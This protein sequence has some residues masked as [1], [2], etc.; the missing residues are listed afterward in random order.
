[1]YAV[2]LWIKCA[3]IEVCEVIV[4]LGVITQ[5]IVDILLRF[6]PRLCLDDLVCLVR[7]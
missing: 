1:M 7:T 3:Q 4:I 2:N 6:H 5:D